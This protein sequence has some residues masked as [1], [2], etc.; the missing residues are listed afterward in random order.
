MAHLSKKK[1]DWFTKS[2]FIYFMILNH[3]Y[4]FFLRYSI[5]LIFNMVVNEFYNPIIE[6]GLGMEQNILRLGWFSFFFFFL[7]WS[8]RILFQTNKP[9]SKILA[10]L[11]NIRII[12]LFLSQKFSPSIVKNKPLSCKLSNFC[13][14]VFFSKAKYNTSFRNGLKL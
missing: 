6:V 10:T 3:I 12:T 9:S 7:K 2:E 1:V 5:N 11:I 13:T 8:K 14:E 4:H